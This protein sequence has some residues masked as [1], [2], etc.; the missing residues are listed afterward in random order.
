MS[1]NERE[2]VLLRLTEALLLNVFVAEGVIVVEG[3][4]DV[5]GVEDG[6]CV[7]DVVGVVV[8]EEEGVSVTDGLLDAVSEGLCVELSDHVVVRV[9][10]DDALQLAEADAEVVRDDEGVTVVEGLALMLGE[11]ERTSVSVADELLVKEGEGLYVRLSN[12]VDVLLAVGDAV[13]LEEVDGESVPESVPVVVEDVLREVLREVDTDIVHECD[14]LNDC[15]VECDFEMDLRE[16][17][18]LCERLSVKEDTMDVLHEGACVMMLMVEL[19]DPEDDGVTV[20]DGVPEGEVVR[21]RDGEADADGTCVKDVV[22]FRV[23]DHEPDSDE[24]RDVLGTMVCVND[25]L[26]R[27]RLLVTVAEGVRL[28]EDT[29]E[30][31][32]VGDALSVRDAL[33][34]PL[35]DGDAVRVLEGNNVPD[36]DDTLVADRLGDG[37]VRDTDREYERKL[38]DE[39]NVGVGVFDGDGLRLSDIDRDD[40]GLAEPVGVGVLG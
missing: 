35:R 4:N 40:V 18:A 5:L 32:L 24:V 37:A 13:L 10:V 17:E 30:N 38:S 12:G 15:E 39:S 9:G 6:V 29:S 2:L 1:H 8:R 31:V 22:A 21:D 19:P 20:L 33:C 25:P 36:W 16:Y 34:V 26:R 23:G 14:E 3:V 11:V 28:R 7:S 27:D